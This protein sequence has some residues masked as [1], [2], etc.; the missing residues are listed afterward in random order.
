ML[1][2]PSEWTWRNSESK[3]TSHK[4]YFQFHKMRKRTLASA[5]TLWS[6]FRGNELLLYLDNEGC[7][8]HQSSLL[9]LPLG[10]LETLAESANRGYSAQEYRCHWGYSYSPSYLNPF[11]GT[12]R[13]R[14]GGQA[15]HCK[16]R[17]KKRLPQPV[18]K[19]PY[20]QVIIWFPSSVDLFCKHDH[21]L[22]YIGDKDMEFKKLN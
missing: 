19:Q 6:I 18:G 16:T 21:P 2:K 10:W 20:P 15:G 9:S 14:R 8:A 7:W 17:T 1:I 12:P 13:T 4:Y 5:W 3:W 11:R 22:S